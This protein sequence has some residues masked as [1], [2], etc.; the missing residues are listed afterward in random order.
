M[1]G[2]FWDR[3]QDLNPTVVVS[4]L[5]G[6]NVGLELDRFEGL[7]EHAARDRYLRPQ[8]L[9]MAAAGSKHP[10][11]G[12][13]FAR[14]GILVAIKSLIVAFGGRTQPSVSDPR[15]VGD[16]SL[17]ANEIAFANPPGFQN[18]VD[19]FDLAVPFLSV[20]DLY[21]PR[22]PGYALARA[23]RMIELF[24]GTDSTVENLRSQLK[25]NSCLEFD[26]LQLVD[27]ASVAFGLF[28]HVR[29][30]ADINV[31]MGSSAG[32]VIDANT[33]LSDT[34]VPKS[35]LDKFLSRR[36]W[37]FDRF[38]REVVG[39]APLNRA[40][41]ASRLT[42]PGFGTDFRV[43]REHPLMDL[44][45]GRHLVLDLEFLEEL[46]GAGLF[47]HLLSHLEKDQRVLLFELWGRI[48][49]L[50][51]VELFEHFYPRSSSPLVAALFRAD[52]AFDASPAQGVV[53]GQVDGM[54]DLGD[55]VF[56]FEF[57][58]FLLSQHVKD[59]VDRAT[60][61][62]ELRLKL[63]ENEKGE[64]KAVRQLANACAAVREGLIPTAAGSATSPGAAIIY[65][66]VVVADPVMEAFGVN[67]FLNDIFEQYA[68]GITGEVRPLTVMSIQ[69]LEEA[70]A[71]TSAGTFTWRD[72]F[73]SRFCRDE[74]GRLRRVRLW[75]VHQSTYDILAAKRAP[76]LP[77]QFRRAQFERIGREIISTYSG[78]RPTGMADR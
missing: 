66:I 23:Y 78:S 29:A 61:E 30:R 27:F 77:N 4:A 42:T 47:F 52:F 1:P 12:A 72:L 46:V 57:K 33:L 74:T 75:S 2:D 15:I 39:E 38:R 56:L 32:F 37:T 63:V 19:D 5:A 36:S 59:T 40:Q 35:N 62:Q 68:N 70:L 6:I 64:P 26:G 51:V 44:G 34:A 24:Q 22:F 67:T 54:L 49:E 71:Y 21:N 48:F 58:H 50:L 41:F 13:F 10:T 25:T 8:H 14:A 53:A 9:P 18:R 3:M 55:A 11:E 20:W 17:D 7:I 69:E 65:P 16:L 76:S 31:L 45:H 28:A 60:L 73:D 43:F